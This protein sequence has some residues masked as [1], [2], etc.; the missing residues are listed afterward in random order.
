MTFAIFSEIVYAYKLY[1]PFIRCF[2]LLRAFQRKQEH[3][4]T[5]SEMAL[6]WVDL[7]VYKYMY[8]GDSLCGWL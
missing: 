4:R 3:V 7:E 2:K 1:V 6:V 8:T 5:F